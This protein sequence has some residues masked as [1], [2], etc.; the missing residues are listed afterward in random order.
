MVDRTYQSV[1]K[2][3]L[4]LALMSMAWSVLA[5]DYPHS[6]VR[7]IVA[8]PPGGGTDIVARL[9]SRELTQKLGQTVVVENVPGA[10]GNIG[11][12]QVARAHPDGYTLLMAT[13]NVTANPSIYPKLGYDPLKDFIGVC[14]I[15]DMPLMLVINPSLPVKTVKEL[16]AYARS[17]PGQL[18]YASNGYGS[19]PHIAGEL[20]KKMAKVNIVHIPYKGGSQSLKDLL[21]DRV[22]LMFTNP[23][24][25]D[26]YVKTRRLRALAV[27]SETRSGSWP[28]LPTMIES[29][30]PGFVISSW[31]G[32]LAPRDTPK[33]IVHKL[34]NACTQ[35]LS[36]PSIRKKLIS[37]GGDLAGGSIAAFSKFLK[38]DAKRW[39]LFV[40]ETGARVN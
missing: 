27:T 26:P 21:A 39:Q 33:A 23:A 10:N 35:T 1:C 9:M 20:F 18:S 6:P 24:P 7:M 38:A 32:I 28:R 34:H 14:H 36:N 25:A 4:A 13:A 37:F 11:T 3:I 2:F 17:K 40:E 19:S 5:Q 30:F 31:R 29:G 8:Y 12:R 16:I 15:T 22:Q